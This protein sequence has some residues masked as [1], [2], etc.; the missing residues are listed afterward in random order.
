MDQRVFERN[1]EV[2]QLTRRKLS[3]VRGQ[4]AGSQTDSD[5]YLYATYTHV[6]GSLKL[7]SAQAMGE[8]ERDGPR[9]ISL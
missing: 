5:S 1:R 2:P 6:T 3:Q 8:T 4:H 7:K 9:M